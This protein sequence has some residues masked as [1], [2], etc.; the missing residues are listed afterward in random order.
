ME[1]S[2]FKLN[3]KLVWGIVISSVL[4]SIIALISLIQQWA[5]PQV[6]FH[7]AII[8]SA[9]AWL[10]VIGDIAFRKFYHKKFWIIYMIFFP[11]ITPLIYLFQRKNL[12]SINRSMSS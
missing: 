10:I 6:I 8:L 1:Y 11:S 9:S 3:Y 12:G 2:A 5:A 4:F 7:A